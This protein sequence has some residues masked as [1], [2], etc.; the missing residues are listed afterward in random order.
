MTLVRLA[1]AALVAAAPLAS[2]SGA[3]LAT[4]PFAG[5]PD[6]LPEIWCYGIRNPWGYHFDRKTGELWS[7]DVGQ[8]K[9]EEIDIIR[10]G[11]NYGWN[12]RE[13][14]H[15]FKP[16]GAGPFEEPLVEH[17]HAKPNM[18]DGANS[19]TGGCVSTSIPSCWLRSSKPLSSE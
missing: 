6:V 16:G 3:P 17:G 10:K 14:K 1:C 18:V 4:N 11:A 8:D 13:G 2:V 7:A 9:W 15:E 19:L 5:K 12:Y